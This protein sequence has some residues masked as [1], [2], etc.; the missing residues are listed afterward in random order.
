MPIRDLIPSVFSNR[1]VPAR[2]S[3]KDPIDGLYRDM[4]RLFDDFLG[5]SNLPWR[6]STECFEPCLDIRENDKEYIIEAEIPGM[7]KKDVDLAINN[8]VLTI[9]GEKKSETKD[10]N[11]NYYRIERSFGRF[12]RDIPLPDDVQHDKINAKFKNGLLKIELPK[13][14]EAQRSV[15]RIDIQSE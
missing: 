4:N 15:K 11:D 13:K 7:D 12:S 6:A 10:K 9:R 8:D 5:H 3:S 2:R 1:D 14:P